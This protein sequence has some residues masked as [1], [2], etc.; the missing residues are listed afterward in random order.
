[1]SLPPNFKKKL[2]KVLKDRKNSQRNIKP[3]NFV[4]S[5]LES[6]IPGEVVSV[7]TGQFY[8]VRRRLGEL[9]FD[10]EVLT[11]KY[12]N[13]FMHPPR[14]RPDYQDLHDDV[15]KFLKTEPDRIVFLDAETTGFANTP[16]FLIGIMYFNGENFI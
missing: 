10:E 5:D 8:L 3:P 2:E 9:H 7:D 11:K 16:L 6:T 4:S 13:L 12:N 14:L 1:M 15:K